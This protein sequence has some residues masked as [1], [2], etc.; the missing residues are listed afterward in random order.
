MRSAIVP[1]LSVA[2]L[3]GCCTQPTKEYSL[4]DAVSKLRGQLAKIREECRTDRTKCNS[5]QYLSDVSITLAVTSTSEQDIGVSLPVGGITISPTSKN[6]ESVANTIT[7]KF[8]SPLFAS[9]DALITQVCAGKDGKI[10]P[11]CVEQLSPLFKSAI[12]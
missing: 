8:D 4:S 1:L 6:T 10:T 3:G 11:E 2:L 7:L 12:E 5:G 9:K